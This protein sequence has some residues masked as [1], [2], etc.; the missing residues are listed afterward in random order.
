MGEIAD[1]L[2]GAIADIDS[3]IANIVKKADED[4]KRLGAK[5]NALATAAS[6]VTPQA[7]AAIAG[8]KRLG[9]DL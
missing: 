7:E 8:L 4:V 3:E 5:R 1:R 2:N 9:I 6:L